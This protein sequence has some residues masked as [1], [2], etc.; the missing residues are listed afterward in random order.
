[1]L[2]I[3]PF[4]KNQQLGFAVFFFS[5]KQIVH[6][7]RKLKINLFIK[8]VH[9][10]V[11]CELPESCRYQQMNPCTLH[12]QNLMTSHVPQ[13]FV[14]LSKYPPFTVSK[15]L[16]VIQP[17]VTRHTPSVCLVP[18]WCLDG[19]TYIKPNRKPMSNF[20]FDHHERAST[21]ACTG[22]EK[23]KC[24]QW[25]CAHSEKS[26]MPANLT[27]AQW[28]WCK[29]TLNL[30]AIWCKIYGPRTILVHNPNHQRGKASWL[31][32]TGVTHSTP[33]RL[34]ENMI[35][36]VFHVY[37]KYDRSSSF[38]CVSLMGR[39]RFCCVRPSI[40]VHNPCVHNRAKTTPNLM[41]LGGEVWG[42]D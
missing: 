1:M 12:G 18:V 25:N 31:T 14:M 26:E 40:P 20:D 24:W 21:R 13:D 32:R 7:H 27:S 6:E 35:D 36:W 33:R 5:G 42:T 29:S 16:V 4:Q 39:P 19:W 37:P 8:T 41:K 34:Q 10:F 38:P 2:H 9:C 3:E 30:I 11:S 23:W 28:K 17:D 22:S 15:L